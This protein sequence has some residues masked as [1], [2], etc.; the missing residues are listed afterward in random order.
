MMSCDSVGIHRRLGRTVPSSGSK[1][2][3]G[4]VQDRSTLQTSYWFLAPWH[5][6]PLWRWKWYAPPKCRWTAT[7]PCVVRIHIKVLFTNS[8]VKTFRSTFPLLFSRVRYATQWTELSYENY[9]LLRCSITQLSK[10]SSSMKITGSWDATS[11]NSVNWAQAWKLLAPEVTSRSSICRKPKVSGECTTYIF[12]VRSTPFSYSFT[13]KKEATTSSET[14][15]NVY[16]STRHLIPQ[17]SSLIW[18]KTRMYS[19]F[20]TVI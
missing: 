11:R 18:V 9:W 12:K 14:T 17:C 6:L 1:N 7:E 5:I 20:L 3:P 4:K 19:R 8:T 10:L 15:V 16:R 13:L 2:A